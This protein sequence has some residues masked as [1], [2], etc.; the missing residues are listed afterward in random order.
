MSASPAHSRKVTP[1]ATA[2]T[3]AARHHSPPSRFGPQKAPPLSS[4]SA[5]HYWR[6]DGSEQLAVLLAESREAI[7]SADSHARIS[8][9]SRG[10]EELLGYRAADLFGRTVWQLWQPRSRERRRLLSRLRREHGSLQHFETSVLHRDGTRLPVR[11]SISCGFNPGGWPV[12]YLV[13]LHDLAAQ[14]AAQARLHQHCRELESYV[15]LI[16]HSLKGPLLA[17]QGFVSLLREEL[18]ARLDKEHAH[19]LD[20]IQHNAAIMERRI[21]DLFEFFRIGSEPVRR[22]WFDPGEVIAGVL[23]ELG[24]MAGTNGPPHSCDRNTTLLLPS[25]WP[26]LFADRQALRTVLENLLSNAMKYRR[27]EVALRLEIGWRERPAGHEFWV[28]DNGMGMPAEFIPKAFELFQRGPQSHHI[29][30]TGAGLAIVRRLIEN[31]QG[32]VRLES[33]PGEGATVYFTI[34]KPDL[35]TG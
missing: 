23:E 8:L 14:R 4:A 15:H 13:F 25:R 16:A 11:V 32:S 3:P 17:V 24:V 34:P 10:A 27:P 33:S 28:R 1:P 19:F 35:Q 12:A 6:L 20:R 26:R 30:G 29:A 9:V 7:L 2:A 31:H 5:R 18:G 22:E 21:L